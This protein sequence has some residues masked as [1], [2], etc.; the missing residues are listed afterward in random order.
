MK[1]NKKRSQKDVRER[2][3]CLAVVGYCSGK[4]EQCH[5][6]LLLKITDNNE[7]LQEQFYEA[8]QKI[9]VKELIQLGYLRGVSDVSEWLATQKELSAEK[10]VHKLTDLM[11]KVNIDMIAQEIQ[12]QIDA[13]E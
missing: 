9:Y 12:L 10:I 13:E 5:H 8:E 3:T 1:R 11:S 2:C 4:P 6:R 7:A